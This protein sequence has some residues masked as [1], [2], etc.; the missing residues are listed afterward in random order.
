LTVILKKNGQSFQPT[1]KL[2]TK[3]K[4]KEVKKQ[5]LTVFRKI[6]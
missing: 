6:I 1:S 3:N 4:H 2:L 5:K